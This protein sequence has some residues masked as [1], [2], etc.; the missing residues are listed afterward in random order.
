MTKYNTEARF[1]I[2]KICR[3]M[4]GDFSAKDIISKLNHPHSLSTIYRIL[5]QLVADNILI[6]NGDHYVNCPSNC[7]ANS[8]FF[9]KCQKC[10]KTF[11]IDCDELSTLEQHIFKEHGFKTNLNN[12]F[13]NGLCQKCQSEAK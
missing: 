3:E 1:H 13:L 9:L 8:H 11:H 4:A 7:D 10:A 12:S 2:Y 5:D 6:K